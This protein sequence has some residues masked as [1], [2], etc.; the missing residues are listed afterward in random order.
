LHRQGLNHLIGDGGLG[1]FFQLLDGMGADVDRIEHKGKPARNPGALGCFQPLRF[2]APADIRRTGKSDFLNLNGCP[3]NRGRT[4]PSGPDP[5]DVGV[6]TIFLAK[7]RNRQRLGFVMVKALPNSLWRQMRIP[8]SDVSIRFQKRKK[9][10]PGKTPCQILDDR[11][12]FC[13]S[14][15]LARGM[16]FTALGPRGKA[17]SYTY[18]G[19]S[20][21]RIFHV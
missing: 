3:C 17:T 21:C 4:G 15:R 20:L 19:L 13:V 18:D 7:R 11:F 6:T 12:P 5:D 2:K 16:I 8:D 9:S 10:S 1:G 14:R